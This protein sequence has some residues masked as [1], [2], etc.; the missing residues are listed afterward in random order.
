M[1]RASG[2][3][4]ILQNEANP[5]ELR[6]E[7]ASELLPYMHPK[8]ASIEA[9]TGGVTHEDRLGLRTTTSF[10]EKTKSKN[11]ERGERGLQL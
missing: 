9:R 1:S 6:F 8:L 2:D 5:L 4:D 7:A 10:S 11:D 3:A